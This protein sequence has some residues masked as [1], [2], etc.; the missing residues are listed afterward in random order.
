[1]ISKRY[2]KANNKYMDNYDENKKSTFIKYLDANNLYGWAMSKPLPTHGFKFMNKAEVKRWRN[3]PC[4]LEVDLDYPIEL[5]ELHNEYPLAPERLM[6]NKVE[7]LIPNLNNK[8]KYVLHHTTLKLYESLGLKITNIHRGITF[9]ESDWLG[10]YINLNTEL[11]T[12]G[13]N[14]FEKDFFK[15]M[16]NSVFG[17][18]MENIRNS[19]ISN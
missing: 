1:M 9:K 8:K 3:L 2:A 6:I 16:N 7:K 13:K 5:H 11:R 17:K 14:D 15:L 10:Q 18:T 4:I 19:K 12:K